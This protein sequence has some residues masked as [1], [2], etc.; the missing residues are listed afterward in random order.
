MLR[1][2][3]KSLSRKNRTKKSLLRQ[4]KKSASREAK[5]ALLCQA[6]NSISRKVK[7][8]ASPCQRKAKCSASPAAS[9]AM[10]AIQQIVATSHSGIPADVRE[11]I[12]ARVQHHLENRNYSMDEATKRRLWCALQRGDCRARK[13]I[14]EVF[15]DSNPC[16]PVVCPPCAPCQDRPCPKYA[17]CPPAAKCPD[18]KPCAPCPSQPTCPKDGPCP[19]CAPAPKC[20]PCAT[21]DMFRGK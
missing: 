2:I 3:K 13:M 5:K 18:A 21:Q 8:S 17:P 16:K 10:P 14:V 11:R 15:K 9:K 12:A 19:P 6:R 20:V 4:A 1:E 7:T